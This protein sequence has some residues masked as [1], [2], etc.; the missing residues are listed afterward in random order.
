MR[1][2]DLHIVV[3]GGVFLIFS[4]MVAMALRY[5]YEARLVPLV[6]GLPAAILAGWQ[7]ARE[8]IARGA[9]LDQRRGASGSGHPVTVERDEPGDASRE[10]IAIVWLLLFTMMVVGGGF[11]IG[12]TLAVVVCQRIWLR[13]SWRTAVLG[14]VIAFSVM[15]LCFERL[16][17]LTLFNGLFVDWINR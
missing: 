10:A 2:F 5:T 9:R 11:V 8:L 15:F 7:L 14:G 17:G 1:R 4:V 6:I 13:E 16:L 12:G 3:A